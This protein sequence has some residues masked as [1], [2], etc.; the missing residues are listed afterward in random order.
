MKKV[1]NFQLA[2]VQPQEC[3]LAF[4]WFF[5][6]VSGWCCLQKKG[7]V[8]VSL[9]IK[10]TKIS[11]QTQQQPFA[12][13]LFCFKNLGWNPWKKLKK[14]LYLKVRKNVRIWAKKE[15]MLR[16]FE[17]L[18]LETPLHDYLT[19]FRKWHQGKHWRCWSSK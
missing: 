3:C 5:L 9:F 1:N 7:L 11:S 18:F 16:C 10:F 14:E 6:P 8:Q 17:Q 2:K 15:V 13:E 4:A 19:S 12:A